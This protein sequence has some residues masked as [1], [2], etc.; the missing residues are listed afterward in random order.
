MT[1]RT[2]SPHEGEYEIEPGVFVPRV[3]KVLGCIA[4][5]ALIG[6]ARNTARDNTIREAGELY[7][8]VGKTKTPD[9]FM[10]ALRK[11]MTYAALTAGTEDAA[12]F[13]TTLHLRVE[14]EMRRELGESVSIPKLPETFVDPDGRETVHPAWNA[15]QSY[16][17]WRREHTV[18][19]IRAEVRVVSRSL[20][21]AG[22]VD[23]FADVDD[24]LTML[25]YK[26]SKAVYREYRV[27]LAAY[28]Q[29]A[30]EQGVVREIV[31]AQIIRFPKTAGDD[32]EPVDVAP[33]EQDE[34]MDVFLAALTL[35]E[36]GF[37]R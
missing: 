5:P 18:R 15:Y 13:G 1:T 2:R 34:L 23:L 25:D 10:A 24:V 3:T 9:V 26:T 27:Q 17:A 32:F 36:R 30:L 20:G 33:S 12:D 31:P 4:K 11:R 16:L 22:T 21:Y 29:A 14:A 28:R 19:P 7:A 37:G 35:W 6:W 8:V